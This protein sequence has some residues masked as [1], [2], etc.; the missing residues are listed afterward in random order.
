MTIDFVIDM[1]EKE[2]YI[3]HGFIF[4]INKN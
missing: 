2:R 1:N 3:G 4:F